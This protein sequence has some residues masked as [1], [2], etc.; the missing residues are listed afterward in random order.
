MLYF[1][2]FQKHTQFAVQTARQENEQ[3][4]VWLKKKSHPV[5]FKHILAASLV[6]LAAESKYFHFY[7]RK[8]EIWL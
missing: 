2:L 8:L 4:E 7:G 3:H 6:L 1:Y 5:S